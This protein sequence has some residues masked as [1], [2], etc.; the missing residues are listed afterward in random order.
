[1]CTELSNPTVYLVRPFTVFLVI[2][3]WRPIHDILIVY[4]LNFQK[5]EIGSSLGSSQKSLT[6]HQNGQEIT[7][8]QVAPNLNCDGARQ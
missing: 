3:T 7:F 2:G 1:M 8:M 6:Y 5:E 4:F